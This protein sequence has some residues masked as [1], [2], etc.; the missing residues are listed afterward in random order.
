M[1][2]RIVGAGDGV[3]VRALLGEALAVGDLA[4]GVL[5]ALG[6]VAVSPWAADLAVG[7]AERA[8]MGAGTEHADSVLTV[9]RLWWQMPWIQKQEPEQEACAVIFLQ[10]GMH[11]EEPESHKQRSPSAEQESEVPAWAFALVGGGV[12]GAAVT[13]VLG[14]AAGVGAGAGLGAAVAVVVVPLAVGVGAAGLDVGAVA[15]G[16]GA[17]AGLAG[18]VPEAEAGRAVAGA[19]S[20]AGGGALSDGAGGIPDAVGVGVTCGLGDVLVLARSDALVVDPL[21]DGDLGAGGLGAVGCARVEGGDGLAALHAVVVGNTSPHAGGVGDAGF[22]GGVLACAGGLA[23]VGG[24]VE[25]ATGGG[26]ARGGGELLAGLDAGFGTALG[27]DELAVL[28]VG[29]LVNVA[30]SV[31]EAALHLA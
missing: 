9:P 2:L 7:G 23:V 17:R 12:P 27:V 6:E 28:V 15:D 26:G 16:A 4:G 13:R 18:G 11:L 21:A 24:G 1:A 22:L 19:V 10:L 8:E 31:L 5:R 25:L 30:A 3:G 29:A 20:V 14:A